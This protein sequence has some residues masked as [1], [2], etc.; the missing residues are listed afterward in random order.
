LRT[1]GLVSFVLMVCVGQAQQPKYDV[2][3]VKPSAPTVTGTNEDISESGFTASGITP[4]GLLNLA[5]DIPRERITGLSSDVAGNR[6]DITADSQI[7]RMVQ[8]LLIERFGLKW[9]TEKRLVPS[10]DLV[11]VKKADHLRPS[12]TQ[13][14]DPDDEGEMSIR[15]RDLRAK[16]I[17]IDRLA[18]LMGHELHRPVIDKTGLQGRFDAELRWSRDDLEAGES[19]ADDPSTS[20]PLATAIREQLGLK[21]QSKREMVDV[22]VVD[23]WEAPTS[24]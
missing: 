3:T 13:H 5:F 1:L 4:M 18:D 24:N 21:L 17:R 14:D 19:A 22:I 11:F 16:G 23:R 12:S 15:N 8:T 10:F 7:R 2:S 6:F 20:P 9:H